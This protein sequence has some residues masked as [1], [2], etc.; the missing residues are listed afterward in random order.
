MEWSL[1]HWQNVPL[2]PP[3]CPKDILSSG[4]WTSMDTDSVWYYSPFTLPG[5]FYFCGSLYGSGHEAEVHHSFKLGLCN[6]PNFSNTAIS[7]LNTVTKFSIPW[8]RDIVILCISIELEIFI[9]YLW[10]FEYYK[11]KLWHHV[12]Q[13]HQ[14]LANRLHKMDAFII[15]V[16]RYV[17]ISIFSNT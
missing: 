14:A 7:F 3:F 1:L 13:C 8:Y 17:V 11:F 15:S 4:R 6:I 2:W 16:C 9:I 5:W 12:D 10:I